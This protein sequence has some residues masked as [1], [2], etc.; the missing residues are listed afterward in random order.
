MNGKQGEIPA[1][2]LE[3][4]SKKWEKCLTLGKEEK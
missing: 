4:I 1:F 3:N 2:L